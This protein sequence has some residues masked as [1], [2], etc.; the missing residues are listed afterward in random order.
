MEKI[1]RFV[2]KNW[3]DIERIS[4]TVA[5]LTEKIGLPYIWG[6]DN[7]KQGG[8]DCSGLVQ[9]A[10]RRVGLYDAIDRTAQGIFLKMKDGFGFSAVES[11]IEK[12]EEQLHKYPLM[13]LF[14]GKSPQKI[15][16]VAITIG[17]GML[18][19]AGGGGRFT[20]SEK[21]AIKANAFVRKM[22]VW[23]RRDVVAIVDP[24]NRGL[25]V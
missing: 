25:F 17:R 6:G 10:L 22:G 18:V 21:A 8:Y 9:D 5:F 20:K 19:E 7:Q 11:G 2:S 24:F 15:T 23:C 16:H 1:D 4:D 3:N 13:V 12:F 14:Y